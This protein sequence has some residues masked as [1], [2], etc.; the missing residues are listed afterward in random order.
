MSVASPSVVFE[1]T[2]HCTEGGSDK[3]YSVTVVEDADGNASVHAKS[4]RRGAAWVDQGTKAEGV[5]LAVA[6]KKAEALVKSKTAKGY[7]IKGSFNRATG[8]SAPLPP[9]AP[10]ANEKQDSGFRPQLLNA[11]E[12]KEALALLDSSDHLMQQK[13]DGRRLT[14]R[15]TPDEGTVGINKL[16]QIVTPSSHLVE[17]AKAVFPDDQSF[18]L[19]GE[20]VGETFHAFD[21]LALGDGPRA[22]LRLLPY[23]DRLA[24]LTRLLA[25][26][27]AR[28]PIKAVDTWERADLKRAAYERLLAEEAEGVVFKL[29]KAAYAAGRPNS[30]GPHLKAKFYATASFVS[31]GLKP[32]KR[33]VKLGLLDDKAIM[34]DMGFCTI[35]ANHELPAEGAIVEVRYLYALPNGGKV[36]QPTYL[37]L[38]DDIRREECLVAQLKFKPEGNTDDPDE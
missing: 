25:P 32:G 11:I 3:L 27:Q 33:S 31:L 9:A 19:D 22:D 36:Y 4:C 17:A 34:R 18:L 21:L 26:H 12:E 23:Q 30:G 28:G 37:G 24:L 8:G 2:L 29:K 16:G 6:I 10:A 7:Q 20:I 35:P 13:H 38:R 15:R 5:T 14:L 1:Q